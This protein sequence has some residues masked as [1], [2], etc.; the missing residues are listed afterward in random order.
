MNEYV[1][2][3]L[4][5]YEEL[6]KEIN[7][8]AQM[9]SKMSKE[10][11]ELEKANKKLKA[12]ALEKSAEDYFLKFYPNDCTNPDTYYFAIQNKEE[13]VEMGISIDEQI[14]YIKQKL[15]KEKEDE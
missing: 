5:T 7:V 12:Y 2:L 8:Q 4:G 13:L 11:G 10:T 14:E 15:E 3:S 6:K 9:L 1:Q